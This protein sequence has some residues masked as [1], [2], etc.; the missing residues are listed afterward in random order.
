MSSVS[1]RSG[2]KRARAADDD[3]GEDALCA[4]LVTSCCVAGAADGNPA[5]DA[6]G[7]AGAAGEGLRRSGRIAARQAAASAAPQTGIQTPAHTSKTDEDP[8]L[9]V[10]ATSEE[11][12]QQR[13]NLRAQRTTG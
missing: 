2:R 4:K 10:K 12:L 11:R 8:G 7:S 9:G 5:D 13:R 3:G 1:K 6:D